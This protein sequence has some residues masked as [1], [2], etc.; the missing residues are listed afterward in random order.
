MPRGSAGWPL[1]L[2]SAEAGRAAPGP[3]GAGGGRQPRAAPS[4]PQH[5]HGKTWGEEDLGAGHAGALLC[6]VPYGAIRL[7]SPWAQPTQ[8]PWDPSPPHPHSHPQAKA[9]RLQ[10]HLHAQD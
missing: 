7:S 6:S 5:D 9:P 1:S 8:P 3:R 2:I 10:I 4:S